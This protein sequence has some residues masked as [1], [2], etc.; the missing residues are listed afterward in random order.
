MSVN[1]QMILD[2]CANGQQHVW[3]AGYMY[4]ILN[5]PYWNI[6]G[7]F[8]SE[9]QAVDACRGTVVKNSGDDID[10]FIFPLVQNENVDISP[11]DCERIHYLDE[12]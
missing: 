11:F 12:V 10:L 9:K 1:D 7:V 2:D 6:F 3:V 8:S 4:S 5:E